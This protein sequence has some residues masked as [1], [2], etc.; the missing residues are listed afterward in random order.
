MSNSKVVV[1]IE[2][3]DHD[4]SIGEDLGASHS[5]MTS[6][7]SDLTLTALSHEDGEEIIAAAL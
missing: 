1:N 4:E 7:H 3:S 5:E 2:G 6:I